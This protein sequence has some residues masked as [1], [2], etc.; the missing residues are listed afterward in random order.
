MRLI[1][2]AF[3]SK[4]VVI[5]YFREFLNRNEIQVDKTMCS[6]ILATTVLCHNN[7]TIPKLYITA[8]N[9]IWVRIYGEEFD[10]LYSSNYR[11]NN[12]FNLQDPDGNATWPCKVQTMVLPIM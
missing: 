4:M 12:V 8:H 6:H 9:A 2:L 1:Q 3:D 7:F 10:E 5:A 11:W